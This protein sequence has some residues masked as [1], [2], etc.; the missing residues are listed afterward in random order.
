M[1]LLSIW[2]FFGLLA[3][4]I[5]YLHATSRTPKR[6]MDRGDL[7][8]MII[9]LSLGPVGFLFVLAAWAAGGRE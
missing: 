7:S 1:I 8:C 2:V 4:L 9:L 5:Y 6:F 3:G